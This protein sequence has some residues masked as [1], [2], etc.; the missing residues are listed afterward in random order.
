MLKVFNNIRKRIFRLRLAT[1]IIVFYLIILIFS[2]TLSAFIY[3][4]V[5]YNL[6]FNRV[7]QISYQTLQSISSNIT[8]LIGTIN[9][10][11]KMIF[12]SEDVQNLLR[13]PKKDIYLEGKVNKLLNKYIISFPDI[14]SIYLIDNDGSSYFVYTS[15]E[16][17]LYLNYNR[18]ASWLIKSSELKG[19]NYIAVNGGDAFKNKIENDFL[20]FIRV[21]NDIESQKPIGFMII[22]VKDDYFEKSY[23]DIVRKYNTTIIIKDQYNRNIISPYE[24]NNANLKGFF[25]KIHDAG[26]YSEFLKVDNDQILASFMKIPNYDWKIISLMPFSEIEE[27]TQILKLIYIILIFINGSFIFIASVI[28]SNMIR[29]PINYLILSMKNNKKGNFAKIKFSTFINEFAKLRDGYNVMIDEIVRLIR[30]IK[31]EQ[32]IKRKAELDILQ[33]Q[34]KPH[35]LYNTF[36]SVSSLALEG[37]SDEVY[38]LITAL[39]KYYRLSLSKGN[40]MITIGEEITVVKNYLFIQKIRYKDVF[41]DLYEIDKEINKYKILKLILQP[42]VENSIYHGIRPKGESGIIKI[43]AKKKDSFIEFIVEDDGIGMDKDLIKK[44]L[45]ARGIGKNNKTGF[46]LRGTIQRLRIFYGKEDIV[47]IISI[48]RGKTQ[49]II[50]VPVLKSKK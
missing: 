7:S 30:K 17:Y 11:S 29:K 44:I 48:K 22:N 46:G 8:S 28:V 27:E 5:Y 39:G 3:Y 15:Y 42:L 18:D 1:K 43:S 47:K 26:Y 4:K 50:T 40:E 33:A 12:S 25:N 14:I 45:S 16:N 31:I 36:D 21:V 2:F 23:L 20:S 49:I 37:K 41:S 6:M 34:I 10:Y 38:K 19:K 13:E 32:K 9:D 24:V 35:F